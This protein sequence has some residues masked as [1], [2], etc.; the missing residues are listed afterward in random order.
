MRFKMETKHNLAVR[1]AFGLQFGAMIEVEVSRSFFWL[2]FDLVSINVILVP[3]HD[4]PDCLVIHGPTAGIHAVAQH[5]RERLPFRGAKKRGN[6]TLY[7]GD[8][9]SCFGITRSDPVPDSPNI[10]PA[11]PAH[12]VEERKLQVAGFVAIPAIGNVDHVPRFH[13]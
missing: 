13:P 2:D 9:A 5:R 4:G 8:T 6:G 10:L 11:F 1:V 3:V 7:G 12:A